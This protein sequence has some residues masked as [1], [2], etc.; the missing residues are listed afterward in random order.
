MATYTGAAERL[1]AW[2]L[3]KAGEP[4]LHG[5]PGARKPFTFVEDTAGRP[6]EAA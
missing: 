1:K 6:G 4:L 5:V 2:K 3:R